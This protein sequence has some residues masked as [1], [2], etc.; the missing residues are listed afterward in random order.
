MRERESERVS[1][2]VSVSVRVCVRVRLQCRNA[3]LECSHSL[4]FLEINHEFKTLETLTE[5]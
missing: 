3:R 4:C 1:V 5:P 2:C